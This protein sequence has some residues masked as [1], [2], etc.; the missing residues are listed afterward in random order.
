MSG[1]KI[2]CKQ[3]YE[4]HRGVEQ[5]IV[6]GRNEF[7]QWPRY[8]R[9]SSRAIRKPGF[10]DEE[11]SQDLSSR[12]RNYCEVILPKPERW[13]GDKESCKGRHEDSCNQGEYEIVSTQCK[14]GR[15]VC[16]NS[17]ERN[18]SVIHQSSESRFNIQTD[19]KNAKY[20]CIDQ[21]IEYEI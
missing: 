5:K 15:R 12:Y 20:P 10:A 8:A 2:A 11:Q 14:Q 1:D 13:Q 9:K 4:N 6:V 21:S 16:A 3:E 19:C 17:E 18:L 7:S